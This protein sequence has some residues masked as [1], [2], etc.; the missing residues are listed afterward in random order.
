MFPIAT[1][2]Q[3]WKAQRP[4]L[5]K[6]LNFDKLKFFK[7]NLLKRVAWMFDVLHRKDVTKAAPEKQRGMLGERTWMKLKHSVF[8]S[9]QHLRMLNDS[10]LGL[11]ISSSD[12]F[13]PQRWTTE[14]KNWPNNGKNE[15]DD[16]IYRKK[17][18]E[19]HSTQ[20]MEVKFE[21]C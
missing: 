19:W 9:E 16:S 21:C 10:A 13:P 4:I 6:T 15:A 17:F 14:S 18:S 20:K 5:K 11:S 1:D 12:F 7:S 2:Q 3:N 8:F